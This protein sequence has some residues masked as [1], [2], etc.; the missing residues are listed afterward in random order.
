[1][2]TIFIMLDS[3]NRHYL[4]TYGGSWVKTPNIDRLAARG[5]VFDNHYCG[6][7]PCMPARREMMTGRLNFLEAPW[8]PIEPWDDCLPTTLR[9]AKGTYSHLI[10][11]HYHYFHSGGEGYHTLFDSWEL[12]RGEENDAWR[13]ALD[14]PPLPARPAD[15]QQRLRSY[16]ANYTRMDPESDESYSTPRCFM[17][18]IDFVE[19]YHASDNWHLHLELFDPHEPFDCPTRYVEMYDD[20]WQG[21]HFTWPEYGPVRPEIDDERVIS[22]IRKCYAG[23]LTM[24]DFWLGKLLDAMD[25]FHLWDEATLVFSTDH[26]HLLGEHGY[27]AK[28]YMFDF[29][30][31]AHIPLIVCPAGRSSAGQR[32][33]AM[34]AT[35]DLMPTILELHGA[36][37]PEAVQGRS[38][39]PLIAGKGIDDLHLLHEAVL[40]GYFGKDINLI[41]GRYSYCRQPVPGSVVH[42][43]TA[44]PRGFHDFIDREK[45]AG[46]QI[47]RFLRHCHDIPHFRMTVP[48]FRHA[49]APDYNPI[50]DLVADPGQENPIRDAKLEESL[51]DKMRKLLA[52]YQAPG[53]QVIRTGLS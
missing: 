22:H 32:V 31:L 25:R 27:W 4:S 43:H 29:Q 5:L 37:I 35:I 34:T 48:S 19:R 14:L 33:Q 26:G 24:A 12:E 1:M 18:A 49:N 15:K 47:G 46:A 50:Y 9:T 45:L 30:E 51:A 6:S 38:L 36:P 13:P 21:G 7:L 28:N 20:L 23:S 44:M 3:L 2:K 40:F 39:A 11:D 42:H 53:C 16:W 8:G 17:R 52:Q 10:T 41:D